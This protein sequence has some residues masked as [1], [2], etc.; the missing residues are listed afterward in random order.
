MILYNNRSL[1]RLISS[2]A[3]LVVFNLLTFL[4]RHDGSMP[5]SETV[6]RSPLYDVFT[7]SPS[8][9][10]AICLSLDITIYLP[11]IFPIVSNPLNSDLSLL[12]HQS[13]SSFHDPHRVGAKR[14]PVS[15]CVA[16]LLLHD[17]HRS[18]HLR[19]L[20]SQNAVEPP[21]HPP[22]HAARIDLTNPLRREQTTSPDP[23]PHL[24]TATSFLILSPPHPSRSR[25]S[26]RHL[27]TSVLADRPSPLNPTQRCDLDNVVRHVAKTR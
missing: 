2:A 24:R 4:N 12:P 9:K 5:I 18:Y 26:H 22:N 1:P 21:C 25:P 19:H 23:P 8:L 15:E 17:P 20:L 16:P 14:N 7:S 10:P 11:H 13:R 27:K 3:A 6:N